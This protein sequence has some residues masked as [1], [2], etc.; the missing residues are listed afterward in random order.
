MRRLLLSALCASFV[1]CQPHDSELKLDGRPV[2]EVLREVNSGDAARKSQAVELLRR[3][4]TN[5]FPVVVQLLESKPESA[6]DK[7]KSGGSP[8]ARVLPS[9]RETL[10]ATRRSYAVGAFHALG[11]NAAA[12][13][14]LVAPLLN[15]PESATVAAMVL[16]R[17]GPEGVVAVL[18]A[19]TSSQPRVRTA[20]AS[21][22]LSLRPA[23]AAAQPLLLAAL[24]STNAFTVATSA[25]ALGKIG[26]EAA[27]T[28]PEL[29]KLLTHESLDVRIGASSGLRDLG[30]PASSAVPALLIAARASEEALRLAS[31]GA[32]WRI[33]PETAQR[34]GIPNPMTGSGDSSSRAK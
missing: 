22:L 13:M 17:M 16:V 18:Q 25:A 1:G 9:L 12:A 33:A 32:L 10:P 26:V 14:P 5:L 28:A 11:T 20:A 2:G 3:S 19:T 4:G 34:E 6:A 29:A 8:S 23:D 7:Q 15:A 27:L 24:P 31:A 30:P 21:A